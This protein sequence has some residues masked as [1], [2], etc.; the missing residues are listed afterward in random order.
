[1]TIS[2]NEEKSITGDDKCEN[3]DDCNVRP[4]KEHFSIT[5]KHSLEMECI[6]IMA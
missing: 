2:D 4:P 1:M 6:N 3:K 5:R